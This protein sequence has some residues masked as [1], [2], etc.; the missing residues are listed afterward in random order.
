MLRMLGSLGRWIERTNVLAR[1]VLGLRERLGRM[2][3][4]ASEEN[5]LMRVEAL[6]W[7]ERWRGYRELFEL[8]AMWQRLADDPKTPDT[9]REACREW[10]LRYGPGAPEHGFKALAPPGGERVQ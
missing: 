9:V 8:R 4:R 1:E 5:L 3:G 7:K 2:E 10:L 6:E